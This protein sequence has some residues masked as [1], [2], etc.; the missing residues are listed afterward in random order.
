[1]KLLCPWLVL[2]FQ[3]GCGTDGAYPDARS[4]TDASDSPTPCPG[5][6]PLGAGL[7][8]LA[9][10]ND[11][12]AS[13]G[14]RSLVRFTNPTNIAVGADGTIYVAD[15]DGDAIRKV[16]PAGQ[17]STLTK[18]ATFLKPFGLVFSASGVLYAQTD[19]NDLGEHS[20]ETGTL[21]TINLQ[22]GEPTMVA[23]NLGRPRGLVFLPDGRLVMSDYQHHTVSLF[24]VQTKT[25]TLL[26]GALDTPGVVDGIGATARFREPWGVALLPDGRIAVAD[27]G[28]HRIRAITTTGE[29]T[30]LAGTGAAGRADGAATSAQFRQ[31]IDLT[32]NAAGELFITD[33]GN[34]LIRRL[35]GNQ[36][37]TVAGDGSPGSVDATNPLMGRIYGLEGIDMLPDANRMYITDGSRGDD[38]QPHNS[39]RVLTLP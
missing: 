32:I 4:N 11:T 16:T 33:A 31:P 20:T 19:D 8:T 23:R 1:M 24:N 25:K 17:A 22:T 26:A 9:G 10:C 12:G 34:Y 6:Q 5:Q 14:E 7:S 35:S 15:F 36:V 37:T 27:H 3:I 39:V 18:Q 38:T 21:W 2:A 28:N 13:D 30:T 29:V